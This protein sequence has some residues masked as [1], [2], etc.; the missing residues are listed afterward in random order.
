MRKRQR[1]K[2]RKL[3]QPLRMRGLIVSTEMLALI[4]TLPGFKP[5]RRDPP[6]LK[7]L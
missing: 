2:L 3:P 7:E 1:K 5:E 6:V 4:K